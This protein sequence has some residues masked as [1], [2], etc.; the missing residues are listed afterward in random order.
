MALLLVIT[1]AVLCIKGNNMHY[2]F[3]IIVNLVLE[4]PAKPPLKTNLFVQR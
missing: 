1:C 3:I 4:E 2:G